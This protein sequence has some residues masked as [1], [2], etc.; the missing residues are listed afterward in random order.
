[1][2]RT[3]AFATGSSGASILYIRYRLENSS[4]EARQGRLFV[5]I[6][7]FQVTPT[8][9]NWH[10]FGGVSAITELAYDADLVRVNRSKL[11]I[12]LTAPSQFGAAAFAQ[13][14]ITEYLKTGALP[15]MPIILPSRAARLIFHLRATIK[16]RSRDSCLIRLSTNGMSKRSL[17]T[18]RDGRESWSAPM[19]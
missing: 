4:P 3:T 16:E 11:V 12:P 7:P 8:W 5:A 18:L 2:L 6:R 10:G 1:M 9:Q 19:P 13:G 15:L 14:A 17:L